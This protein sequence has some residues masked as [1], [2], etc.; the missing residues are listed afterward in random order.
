M[1]VN[2]L[3]STIRKL[4][5]KKISL[6]NLEDSLFLLKAEIERVDGDEIEIEINPD[7]QDMLSAEGIVRALK[8]FLEIEPGPKLYRVKKSGKK[9]LVGKGLERIRPYISCGIVKGVDINEDLL[10]DYMHLQES[11]TSTHGRNRRKAS[12]GLYVND[13]IRFPVHYKT[14]LPK[15]II[16]P[17]L[18]YTK[19]LDGPTILEVHEKGPIY[20]PIISQFK[21]WPL[22]IDD[23]DNT[24]SLPPVINSNTLGR[25]STETSNIFVE[26]TG[27]HIP[28]VNQAL[29]I[30]IAALAERGGQIESVTTEYPDGTITETPDMSYKKQI[31][32]TS[33]VHKLIGL[34]LEDN[35]VVKCLY[36]MCYGAKVKSK[37]KIEVEIPP[38]RTDIL[39]PVDIIEDIAIGYGFDKIEPEMPSTHT[40]GKL[41]PLTRLKN[42]VR[43]LMIGIGFQEIT[44]YIMNSPEIMNSKMR[45]NDQLVEVGNPKSRDYSVLRNSLLP[46]LVD[47]A[48]QNQHA[49]YPQRIFEVGDIVR[50][51]LQAETRIS[52]I[53]SVA[54]LVIDTMVNITDLITSLGFVLRN[55]GLDNKFELKR[56]SNPS[57]IE[58]RTAK[59]ILNGKDY[60]II[61]EISP[62]VLM[63]F[64]VIRPI[65]AFEMMLPRDMKW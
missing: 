55:L 50:P 4:L 53:G 57:F 40:A 26:V 45:R 7:R 34:K 56:T 62:E 17:P 46:I 59:I 13:D 21:K 49:D 43:D 2:C 23:N 63:N 37:G 1:I 47:F 14:E 16:F 42:K 32:R 24:L 33:E 11:L 10:I 19:S 35:E 25:L 39:H 44:S 3:L 41:L 38:Y 6:E 22:L 9:V 28:T 30:M 8:G 20:G 54:G 29:N 65:V 5:G 15:K 52:Q 51:D 18:G 60:G 27:T 12:I 31:I 64:N 36:K 58:G 61:G 48:S